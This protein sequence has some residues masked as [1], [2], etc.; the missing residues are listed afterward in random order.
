MSDYRI[1][2]NFKKVVVNFYTDA[3]FYGIAFYD[4]NGNEMFKKGN[5]DH[6]KVETNLGDDE[7][8]LGIASRN[9]HYA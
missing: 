2:A 8:L 9:E 7:R 3:R 4:K 1:P 5:F 6:T